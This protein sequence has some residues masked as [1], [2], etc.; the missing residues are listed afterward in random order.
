MPCQ[1]AYARQDME[2]LFA[3]LKSFCSLLEEQIQKRGAEAEA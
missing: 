3:E 1:A 2:K